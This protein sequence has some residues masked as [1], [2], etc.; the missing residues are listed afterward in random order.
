MEVTGVTAPIELLEVTGVVTLADAA[1]CAATR[2]FGEAC[3]D[4]CECASALCFTFGDGT[5]A[6]TQTCSSDAECPVG[7][8]GQRCNLM[9]VCRP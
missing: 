3:T 4:A 6:C 7:S 9:G 5:S 8:M 2:A 1:S